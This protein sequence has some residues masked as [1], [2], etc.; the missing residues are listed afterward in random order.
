MLRV[1]SNN[2]EKMEFAKTLAEMNCKYLEL[3]GEAI[4]TF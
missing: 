1:C 4:I 2:K 3:H